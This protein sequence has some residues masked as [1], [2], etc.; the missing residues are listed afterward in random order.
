MSLEHRLQASE[1]WTKS[2]EEQVSRLTRERDEL[3][4]KLEQLW[5]QAYAQED[6]LKAVLAER[7]ELAKRIE[8]QRDLAAN[9]AR[10]VT[11]RNAAQ[12]EVAELRKQK[13]DVYSERNKCVAVMLRMALQLG[14]KAG[15]G[16]H[17][18]SDANWEADWRTIVFIDLP[19]GQVS[20]HFHASELRLLFDAPAYTGEWDGHSTDEKYLRCVAATA[21]SR[22]WVAK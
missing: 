14:L 4:A 17:P 10:T 19:T 21:I 20:W 13:N 9:F 12:A 8:D 5:G 11:E 6:A 2:L 3:K 16:A 22:P 7:H 15:V 1:E 18:A